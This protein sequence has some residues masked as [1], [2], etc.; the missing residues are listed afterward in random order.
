MTNSHPGPDRIKRGVPDGTEVAHKTGTGPSANGL[1]STVNDVGIV[2]LPDGR[3]LVMAILISDAE[4]KLEVSEQ[5]IAKITEAAWNC[6][7]PK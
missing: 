6:W 7:V 1:T 3:H 5:V 2:Q 4:A